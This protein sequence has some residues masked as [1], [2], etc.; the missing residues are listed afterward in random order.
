MFSFRVVVLIFGCLWLTEAARDT[1]NP[2]DKLS[3][4]SSDNLVSPN[5]NVTFGFFRQEYRQTWN[6]K[7]F[8]YYLAMWYAQGT[9]T[10][11]NHSI[12]LANRD[13]LI[14]DDSGVLVLDDTGL[15]ITCTG[16]NPIQ[17]FSLQSTSITINTSGMKVVL[18]DSGNLVLQGTNEENRENVVLWQ[19]FDHPTDS[20]LSGMKLGVSHG[21]NFSLTSWFSDSIPASRS[22]TMEWDPARNRLVVRLRERILWTNGEDFENIG[23]SDP[24][25][26]NYDFTN[27]YLYYTFVISQYTLEEQR[28]NCRTM[29][30]YN[31]EIS[32]QSIY[33]CDGNSTEN[34]CERWEGPKC[35]KKD[36][37]NDTLYGNT[38]LSLNDCKDI[39]W[40]DC[41][42]LG[43]EAE[44]DLGCRFLLGHYEEESKTWIWILISMA[45]ALMIIV[46]L[47][48]LFYLRRRR[49]SR[50]EEEYLLDLMTS[51]DASDVSELQTGN[52][53]HNL[54]I[55]TAGLIMSATNGFS[56]DNLLGKGVFGPVFKG[57][58]GDGQEG[59]IKRLSSGSSQ[60][61]VDQTATHKPWLL[62]FC[63]QG[64]EKMLV[65][66][67]MPNKSLDTCILGRYKY[68]LPVS[69]LWLLTVLLMNSCNGYMSP[70]YAMERIFS[71]KSDVYS[72]GVMVL[73]LVSGQKNSSHFEFDRPLNPAWELWKH[74]GALELMDPALSDSCFKQYQVLR[75]ITLSL[76]CV[77]DNPLD[78]PTMS[79]VVSVLNGE[80]QL[81]LP[82]QPAFSIGIRI[83]ETNIK[84]KEVEIYSLNG[85]TMSTMDAR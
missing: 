16:G 22:F 49:Q 37:L 61:L 3:S 78:R 36:S 43:L 82:K 38:N 21:R 44:K 45:M 54:N 67:Y 65:Y 51:E 6:G 13:D 47:S 63:V 66:E 81:A 34:G 76:L 24:F 26:M 79:D 39:C 23:P 7:S 58:L 35:Q 5:R 84:S 15:K 4:I 42:C 70:E 69:T 19:S 62:G 32:I 9:L 55:Y 60:G 17:V 10:S 1:L 73:E 33:K 64:E 80:M 41:K 48:T 14:I 77:E 25:N 12:W 31:L 75:C 18:Q 53:G 85:L 8:G 57:T 72:F 28:K 59:A 2:G 30:I 11:N 74:G 46:L 52:N 71:E 29:G 68:T 27:K 56:P 20:F 40:K 83:V 50:K